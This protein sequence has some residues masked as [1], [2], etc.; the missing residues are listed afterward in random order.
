MATISK[1]KANAMAAF[2]KLHQESRLDFD[3]SVSTDWSS[4][5]GPHR[6]ERPMM[7]GGH[8]HVMCL[9]HNVKAPK[10]SFTSRDCS[11]DCNLGVKHPVPG[12]GTYELS[13]SENA[14]KTFRRPPKFSFGSAG[15]NLVGVRP[16]WQEK[17]P[18]GPGAYGG[19]FTTFGY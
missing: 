4:S 5:A 15:R 9:S 7:A 18:P 6:V 1:A 10:W 2:Q 16:L 12:P 17:Q 11:T 14:A 19:N 13:P 8:P 3:A